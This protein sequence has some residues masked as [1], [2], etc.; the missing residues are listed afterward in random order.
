[1]A[2][3]GAAKK[4]SKK[5]VLVRWVE[6]DSVGVMPIAAAPNSKDI[7]VGCFTKMTWT[8]KG[9]KLYDV[10]VLKISGK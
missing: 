6:E 5:F 2:A 4:C 8:P 10:E 3:T 7:Y 1:M 9:K